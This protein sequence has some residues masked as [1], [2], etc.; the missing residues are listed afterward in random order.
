[1]ALA[2]LDPAIEWRAVE[3]TE[4]HHGLQGVATSVVDWLETWENHE[5]HPEE[6]IESGE[7]VVV[8]TRLR[9]RGR[10]SGVEVEDRYFAV[11]T[12]RYGRAVTYREYPSKA[13]A[14]EAVGLRE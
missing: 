8:V 11:W 12:I 6:F 9:G 10:Q 3:D 2:A 7:H 1:M 4:V 5:L 13:E 14:L